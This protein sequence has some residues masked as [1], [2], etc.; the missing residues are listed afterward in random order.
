MVQLLTG[1]RLWGGLTASFIG[2]HVSDCA[3]YA[4]Q[5]SVTMTERKEI[6]LFCWNTTA[7]ISIFRRSR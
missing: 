4:L 6:D 3:M 5:Q 2:L 1:G 7:L